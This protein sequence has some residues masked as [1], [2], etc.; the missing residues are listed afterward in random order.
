MIKY[1]E[2]MVGGK[3]G[4]DLSIQ[5]VGSRISHAPSF[6]NCLCGGSS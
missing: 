3:S 4:N 1:C 2:P 5:K 6:T